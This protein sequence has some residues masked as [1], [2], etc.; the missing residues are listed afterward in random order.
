MNWPSLITT[1]LAATVEWVEALTI[2]LAVGLTQGWRPALRGTLLGFVVLAVIVAVF[3][4]LLSQLGFL[5]TALQVLIGV[6]LL[7]FGLRWLSK[8]VLRSAG[9]IAL[10]DETLAFE[11]EVGQLRQAQDAERTGQLMAFQGVLL[12]GLEVAF[13][14]LAFGGST[15]FAR[16]GAN[17]L[18]GAV[19]GALISLAVVLVLGLLT[20]R[21]LARVPENT[22]KYIVG[23]SLTAFGVFW[24]GEGLGVRWPGADLALLWIAAAL[25]IASLLLGR[26]LARPRTTGSPI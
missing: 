24:T 25:L 10:H 12:E 26:R 18:L 11:K 6:L 21:P 22:M 1:F 4:A 15:S 19:L 13:I 23:L 17:P 2:V 16:T 9:V 14:V 5:R 8:A 20:H 3:G 7:L